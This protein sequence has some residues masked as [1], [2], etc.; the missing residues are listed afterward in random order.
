MTRPPHDPELCIVLTV[1]S[2]SHEGGVKE[3]SDEHTLASLPSS[4]NALCTLLWDTKGYQESVEL[5]VP[6]SPVQQGAET[7][8]LGWPA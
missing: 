8:R 3:P 6:V 5:H 1:P 4:C 7:P 2:T